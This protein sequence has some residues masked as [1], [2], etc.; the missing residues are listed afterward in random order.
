[1]FIPT[2][3]YIQLHKELSLIVSL[4]LSFGSVVCLAVT[5]HGLK[6]DTP[7]HPSKLWRRWLVLWKFPTYRLFTDDT[8]AVK[9]NIPS[10]GAPSRPINKKQEREIRSFAKLFSRTDDKNRGLLF[11]MA[12]KVAKLP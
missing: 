4:L 5:F 6:M 2:S 9:P 8:H 10:S 3:R 7:C 12:S 1:M 11:H